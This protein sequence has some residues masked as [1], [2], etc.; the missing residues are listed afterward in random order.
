MYGGLVGDDL[1][2][3]NI[4]VFSQDG[5]FENCFV[6]LVV[7]MEKV[8]FK[9]LVISGWELVG[10]VNIIIECEGNVIYVINGEF[11]Y[12][13]FSCYFGFFDKENKVD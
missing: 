13:V 4:Y 10:G 8:L 9:G 1:V 11:V 12:D 3:E 5:V 2:L 6:I 7:D